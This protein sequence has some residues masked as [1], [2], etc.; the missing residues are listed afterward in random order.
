MEI[1]DKP[2]AAFASSEWDMVIK[3]HSKL[4]DLK[5]KDV[6][7]YRDLMWLFVR[8]DFVAQYKQ[9]I[10]G[11]LWHLVQPVL[12]TIMFLLIFGK[13]AQIPT[14]GIPPVLFYISGGWS[15]S[16]GKDF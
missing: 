10:L 11:P 2:S 6:W 13:I 7:Q 12:T 8:R 16:S 3:P 4:L 1:A 5:I 15:S 14:D 9:T